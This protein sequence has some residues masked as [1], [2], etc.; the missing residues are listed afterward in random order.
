MKVRRVNVNPDKLFGNG[1]LFVG[2]PELEFKVYVDINGC[3]VDFTLD[4]GSDVTIITVTISRDL[5]LRITKTQL[6][7]YLVGTDIIP[8]NVVGESVVELNNKCISI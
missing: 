6:H 7:V 4:T 2:R 1:W 8:L 5:S 3:G